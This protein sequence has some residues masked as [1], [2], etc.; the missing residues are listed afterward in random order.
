[1]ARHRPAPLRPIRRI[2]RHDAG[3]TGANPRRA[4]IFYSPLASQKIPAFPPLHGA[5]SRRSR[6]NKNNNQ[7]LEGQ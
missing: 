5:A 4:V 7:W 3:K 6:N 1:M 2:L